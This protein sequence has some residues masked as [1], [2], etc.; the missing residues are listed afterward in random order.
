MI[1]NS[2]KIDGI[3]KVKRNLPYTMIRNAAMNDSD[4]S[5]KAKGILAYL[6]TLPEDWKV[7]VNELT[8]HAKDGKEATGNGIKELIKSGYIIRKRTHDEVGKFSGYDY[9]VSDEKFK[10]TVSR[11]AVNG[12]PVNGETVNGK[13]ATNNKELNKGITKQKNNKKE[14]ANNEKLKPEKYLKMFE[15][16]YSKFKGEKRNL[17]TE[18]KNMAH[19]FP[20][21]EKNDIEEFKNICTKLV[22]AVENEIRH[23]NKV[24]MKDGF[25]QKWKS[26][27][28]WIE[29]RCWE[30]KFE[31]IK[32]E[33]LKIK[34]TIDKS[35]FQK[36]DALAKQKESAA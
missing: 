35:I 25:N 23:K 31:E 22:P 11:F 6:M 19:H 27:R 29:G 18:W 34:T 8:N 36:L 9:E 1:K 20:R 28:N 2:T 30:L 24:L 32:E 12:K 3:Q 13:P 15:E 7:Y 14:K 17:E 5:W 33:P 21:K 10:N 4:L 16:F 26:M